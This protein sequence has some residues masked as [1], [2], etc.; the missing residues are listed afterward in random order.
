MANQVSLNIV[1]SAKTAKFQRGMARAKQAIFGLKGAVVSLVGVGAMGALSK[2]VI[3]TADRIHKMHL[4]LGAGIKAL[5]EYRG[6]A[7][8]SGVTFNTFAT[9]MQRM[10]RRVS[11]AAKGTG[12]AKGALKELNIDA[13]KFAKLKPSEQFEKLAEAF[14][15]ISNQ[16]DRLRLAMKIFDTEGAAAFLQMTADGSDGLRKMREQ[17]EGFGWTKD[18]IEGF[19]KMKDETTNFGFA[20][21]KMVGE[22][23]LKNKNN[24]FEAMKWLKTDLPDLIENV[25][26]FTN[27]VSD[28]LGMSW[29]GFK[30]G[31]EA[32]KGTGKT[33]A[34][35]DEPGIMGKLNSWAESIAESLGMG[36]MGTGAVRD[37]WSGVGVDSEVKKQKARLSKSGAGVFSNVGST[38]DFWGSVGGA[39]DTLNRGGGTFSNV[40]TSEEFWREMLNKAEK[41][42]VLLQGIKEN[43][44]GV[45]GAVAG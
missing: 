21:E 13:T 25:Q 24:I 23:I 10:V 35:M 41:Q 36:G 7:E 5:S 6:V 2:N 12:E 38:A 8:L 45:A 32:V 34:A 37:F 30:Q 9:A 27:L 20:M 1:L 18:Q 31:W 39:S 3:D 26:V 14:D 28:M 4:R 17:M 42:K 33:I 43:T 11:E 29:E 16:G 40:G 22:M 15:K 19:V 44:S